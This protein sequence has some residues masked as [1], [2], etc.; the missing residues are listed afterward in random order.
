MENENSKTWFK[1]EGEPISPE[2]DMENDN[3]TDLSTVDESQE[4]ETTTEATPQSEEDKTQTEENA[5]SDGGDDKNAKLDDFAKHPAW[6]KREDKWKDRFNEQELKH[7]DEIAK[8]REEMQEGFKQ[9]KETPVDVPNW[10]GGDEDQ[11]EQFQEWNKGLIDKAKEDAKNEVLA[12]SQEDQQRIDEATEYMN[13]QIAEIESETG[14]KV[15]KN[16]LLKF[17]L[18]NELVDTKGRWNYR[19]AHKL[20]KVDSLKKN[21]NSKSIEEKK[22]IAGATTSKSRPE[23]EKPNFMTNEDFENQANRPW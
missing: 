8:I 17:T 2:A 7:S 20:M 12:K 9:A 14:E 16:K 1:P 18:E 19:V 15:D 13:E 22:K 10:F 5:N 6:Q 23:T 21:D 3:S 4:K 11:W